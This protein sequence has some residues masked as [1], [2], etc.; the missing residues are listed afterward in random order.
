ML[1]VLDLLFPLV[2]FLAK[3]QI[4]TNFKSAIESNRLEYKKM[5]KEVDRFDSQIKAESLLRSKT[6]NYTNP[7]QLISKIDNNT[8]NL[9][10]SK[11]MTIETVNRDKLTAQE[12]EKQGN[13]LMGIHNTIG[14][15]ESKLTVV[16]QIT[17]IM[18]YNDLFY[19]FKLYIVVVLLFFANIIVLYLKFR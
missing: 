18:K 10:L 6:T 13:Q 11:A 4:R 14:V 1:Q 2:F 15:A 5:I 9:M 8:K 16:Q 19:R 17:D 7:N 12:L 3:G